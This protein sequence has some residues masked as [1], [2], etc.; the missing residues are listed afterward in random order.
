[1]RLTVSTTGNNCQCPEQRA[2][3]ALL[4]L[5]RRQGRLDIRTRLRGSY[6][7]GLAKQLSKDAKHGCQKDQPDSPNPATLVLTVPSS[8]RQLSLAS[9]M[10]SFREVTMPY[11]ARA[12]RRCL[13]LVLIPGFMREP[14]QEELLCQIGSCAL[15]GS[16]QET[17][18]DEPDSAIR[19]RVVGIRDSS[20][21]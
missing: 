19:R 20:R 17:S 4:I 14:A 18:E 12:D 11:A 13:A 5:H 10:F 16:E 1:M 21:G 9:E 8:A 2:G 7:L 15:A 6:R 3:E